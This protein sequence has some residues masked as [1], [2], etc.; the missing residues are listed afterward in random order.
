MTA[1]TLT[2]D[3]GWND[4]YVGVLKG[5]LLAAA[6]GLQLIDISHTIQ[7]YNIFHGAFVLRNAFHHFPE[8]TIHLI[9]VN[10]LSSE[11]IQFLAIHHDGHFFVGP[12]NGLFSMIMEDRPQEVY[13]ID[14]DS[15]RPYPYLQV[16][17]KAVQHIL[18]H[19][20]LEEIGAPYTKL[21]ERLTLQPVITPSR[22]RG[23]V[24]HID[25]YDNAIVNIRQDTFDQVRDERDFALFFKRHD[26]I[27]EISQHYYDA[28]VGEV[29]C[30][31][32]SSGF[33]EIAIN[34]GRAATLLGLN[35]DD[36]IQ[37]DFRTQPVPSE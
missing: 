1:V 18:A 35:I 2:T 32:N 29:L 26:P 12:D 14:Y 8:G 19:R 28:P 34:M 16:F 20:P 3:F 37:I 13:R 23:T 30:L 5:T 24:I 4:Y 31:F 25:H 33:M 7:P 22:I 27:T 36:T 15:D 17:A 11:E 21:R 10:N 6:P 9:N